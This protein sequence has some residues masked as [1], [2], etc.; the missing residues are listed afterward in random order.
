MPLNPELVDRA[1]HNERFITA[2]DIQTTECLDWVVTVA[3]YV[4]VRYVDAY[5]WPIR[6]ASHA[7]RR[8]GIRTDSRTR[9]IWTSYRELENSS[10]DSRYEFADFTVREVVSLI[11]NRMNQIKTHMLRQ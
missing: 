2:L 6:F 9:P 4:A 1:E 3:F 10:R 11:A 5:F 8:R 7:E